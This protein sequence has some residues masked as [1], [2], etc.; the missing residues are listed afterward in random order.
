MVNDLVFVIFIVL[1]LFLLGNVSDFAVGVIVNKH[2]M[3]YHF[4]TFWRE[5]ESYCSFK[6]F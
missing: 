1:L 5:S 2:K 3:L 4:C 6:I